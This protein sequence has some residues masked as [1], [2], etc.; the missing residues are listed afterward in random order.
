MARSSNSRPPPSGSRASSNAPVSGS[1]MTSGIPSNIHRWSSSTKTRRISVSRAM[2]SAAIS[3]VLRLTGR[4]GDP[5]RSREHALL[6]VL[7]ERRLAR[8]E[9]ASLEQLVPE[10]VEPPIATVGALEVD[11]FVARRARN[12]LAADLNTL[13]ASPSLS[14]GGRSR[15][16]LPSRRITSTTSFTAPLSPA[17]ARPAFVVLRERRAPATSRGTATR[18]RAPSRARASSS[19]SGRGSSPCA[20]G[21][22]ARRG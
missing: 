10:I 8:G 22:R 14:A 1:A 3:L 18:A 17:A 20:P 21:G 13:I 6:S 4:D 11:A 12:D 9:T 19:S 16:V 7:A 5:A 15:S 2:L